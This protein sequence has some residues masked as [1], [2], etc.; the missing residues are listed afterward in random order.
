[1]QPEKRYAIVSPVKDEERYVELTLRSVTAQTVRPIFWVIV[2]DGSKDGTPEIIQRYSSKHPYIRAVRNPKAGERQLAFAEVSA[3]NWGCE[4][5]RSLEYDFIVKLDCDLSFESDYF[6]KLLRRFDDDKQLGI[7]SGVYFEQKKTGVWMEVLMPPYHAAGA[8]KVM[9]R[10]CFEDIRGFV[11]APGWDTVDEIR[12]MGRGWNTLHFRDLRM[13]HHKPEGSTMGAVSTSMMQGEAY[14]RSGG[15]K[16]FFVLKALH[17]VTSRPY[18]L[19]AVGL[20][21][22]YLSAMLVRKTLLVT[23]SEARFYKSLLLGRL[24]ARR[25]SLVRQY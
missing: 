23:K 17:R 16:L 4:L 2:D 5:I 25:K 21:W 13:N 6:E 9:R 3:F 15:S 12:A 10:A 18:L 24:T 20:L 14:Y 8:S 7:A 11:P 1:M 19:S 22:G